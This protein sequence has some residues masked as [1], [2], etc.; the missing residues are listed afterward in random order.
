MGRNDNAGQV[1]DDEGELQLA[2]ETDGGGK[3]AHVFLLKV[4]YNTRI[5]FSLGFGSSKWVGEKI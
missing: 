1:H 2:T 5:R 4:C 3:F